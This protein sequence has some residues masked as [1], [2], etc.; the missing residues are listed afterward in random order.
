MFARLTV[1]KMKIEYKGYRVWAILGQNGKYVARF[2]KSPTVTD[3]RAD[4]KSPLIEAETERE[5]IAR[6]KKFLDEL[7]KTG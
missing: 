3:G 1:R 4:V 5:A 2:V 6:A 7:Y